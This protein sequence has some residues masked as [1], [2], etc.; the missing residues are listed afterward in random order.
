M[1]LESISS[2]SARARGGSRALLIPAAL[3]V[4][5]AFGVGCKVKDPPAITEAWSD[6]FE[7]PTIGSNYY[8]T[9]GGYALEDGVLRTQGS[10]NHPLWLRKR[11]PANARIEFDAWSNTPD[12]DIKVEIYGDGSS[13][14]QD[15]G[16]YTATGYVLVMGGWNNS[17]SLLARGNEHG[18]ELV[19][20]TEPKVEPGRRYHWT[21]ERRDGRIDWWIDGEEFLSYE[22]DRP[23]RGSAAAYFG[24]NNWESD[25][26]FDNLTITPL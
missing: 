17:K 3:G 1:K 15:K 9:G 19:E 10:F 14:A 7:R 18:E 13:H 25:A 21:I 24:F 22:D 12:G 23:L 26:R 6:D 20:R 4:T 2:A 11:L 5:L 16:Q 8:D